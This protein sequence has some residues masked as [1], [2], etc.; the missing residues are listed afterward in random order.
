[1]KYHKIDCDGA[2]V[3]A[4]LVDMFLEAHE[5]ALHAPLPRQQQVATAEHIKR[6]IA[7]FIVV[8]VNEAAFLHAVERNVGVVEIEHDLA[9]VA[10]SAGAVEEMARIVGQIRRKWPK[11]R[12]V[13][14]AD[15]GFANDEL[16]AWCEANRVDYV[17]GLAR[18][19][20]P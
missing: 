11:V 7:V 3:D 10:G 4:L 6:E 1:V 18:N 20:R 15:S 13:L 2:K 5:R 9:N 19:A 17:F 14:R 16:M 12:I 8:A